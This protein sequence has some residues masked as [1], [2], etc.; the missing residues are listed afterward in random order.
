MKIV[1]LIRRD[2]RSLKY[3]QSCMG[4][5]ALSCLASGP[6]FTRHIAVVGRRR[7]P[8]EAIASVVRTHAI[9]SAAAR[10]LSLEVINVRQFDIRPRGLIVIA[11][12]VEPRNRKGTQAPMGGR[13]VKGDFGGTRL[14]HRL[15]M[16][17]PCRN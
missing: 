10:Q 15:R 6:V 13:A 9:E 14:L 8:S 11:I 2:R 12:L 3:R 4:E 17:P 5:Y 16:Q 1:D 7:A